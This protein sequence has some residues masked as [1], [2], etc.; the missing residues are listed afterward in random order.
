MAETTNLRA[1]DLLPVR[2]RVSWGA[3]IAGGFVALAAAVLL[4]ALGTALGFT[5]SG[6]IRGDH[7]ATAAAIWGVFTALVAL[8]LGGL[9]T[10]LFT[11]GEDKAEA[12]LYGVVLWGVIF[13]VVMMGQFALLRNM[14]GAALGTANVAANVDWDRLAREANLNQDQ[15]NRIRA[16]IPS[17]ADMQRAADETDFRNNAV[18]VSWWSLA[19]IV[20]SMLAA[21]AGAL[22]GCGP[23]PLLRVAVFRR[24]TVTSR[25]APLPNP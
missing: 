21:I 24:T 22:A 10:T 19:A 11:A 4:L 20:V 15:V 7:I 23:T 2:S 1:E 8:F 14:F 25:G 17:A 9:V 12:V 3:I 16:A 18:R 6:S 13:A 5:A